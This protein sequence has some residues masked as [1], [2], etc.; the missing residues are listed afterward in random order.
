MLYGEM[1]I[2]GDGSGVPNPQILPFLDAGC[3]V[4]FNLF[5]PPR[6]LPRERIVSKIGF[7]LSEKDC[8]SFIIP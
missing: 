7:F 8:I 5:R 3:P 6:F 2:A 4:K 1:R